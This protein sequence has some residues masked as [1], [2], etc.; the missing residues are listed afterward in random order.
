M[1]HMKR[2]E[3]IDIAR[4]LLALSV[5]IY[6]Y[7]QFL[8][9][10]WLKKFHP[11]MSAGLTSV[12]GFFMISGFAL[13][14]SYQYVDFS[15]PQNT[16]R[17]FVKRFARIAPLF[18]LCMLINTI[19]APLIL[20]TLII[21]FILGIIGKRMPNTFW[22]KTPFII[23]FITLVAVYNNNYDR[24]LLM[25]NLTFLFGFINP[26]LTSV[27]GGWS[28]GIEYIFYFLL[29]FILCIAQ[30]NK[31]II[32][33]MAFVTYVLA[34]NYQ[35]F[36]N[37]D[38]FTYNSKE[39][40]KE[41]VA[42]WPLYT[43]LFN[44]FYFFMSGMGLFLIYERFYIQVSNQQTKLSKLLVILLLFYVGVDIIVDN[45]S[46]G[47]GRLIYSLITIA[48]IS[49]TPFLI[50]QNNWLK[51]QLIILGDISYSVYLMQ[52][53]VF[54]VVT[55]YTKSIASSLEQLLISLI[56]LIVVANLTY[57]LYEIP[58]KKWLTNFHFDDLKN[59]VFQMLKNKSQYE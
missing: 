38:L 39:H 59:S 44:H 55:F 9:I 15:I 20:T 4:G 47:K 25:N 50:L 27:R 22:V 7:V 23:I 10:S 21:V 54:T 12:D 14:Y 26:N 43:H 29:P 35:Y 16:T 32:F 37:T 53:P 58:T 42:N 18:Y 46:H 28:I 49:I 1:A 34:S 17:Y 5:A 13:F 19:S 31:K 36:N 8:D 40:V 56:C 24:I 30:R 3:G 48:I 52:F 11:I 2:I 33:I 45:P 51:K 6:H 41:L 57:R